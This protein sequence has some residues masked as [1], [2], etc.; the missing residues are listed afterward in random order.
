MVGFRSLTCSYPDHSSVE[1][2]EDHKRESA[3]DGEVSTPCSYFEVEIIL[4]RVLSKE[5]SLPMS[6]IDCAAT[7]L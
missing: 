3:A 4:V 5:V 7:M 2:V 6:L 1:Y